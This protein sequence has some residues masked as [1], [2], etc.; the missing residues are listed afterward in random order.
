MMEECWSALNPGEL[1]R[2]AT[3]SY[4]IQGTLVRHVNAAHR[5]RSIRIVDGILADRNRD[6]RFMR[7]VFE[8]WHRETYPVWDDAFGVDERDYA[9]SAMYMDIL[10]S[11]RIFVTR[12]DHAWDDMPALYDPPD[13][14]DRA[15]TYYEYITFH[16]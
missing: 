4:Q 14:D 9:L 11:P 10:V 2:V 15:M 6:R 3:S 16:H 7:L 8:L 13:D 5:Q 12:Y 1:L